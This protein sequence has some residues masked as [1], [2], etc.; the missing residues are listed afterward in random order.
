MK[1]HLICALIAAMMFMQDVRLA[2]VTG[3]VFDMEGKPVAKAEVVFKLVNSGKTYKIFTDANGQFHAVGLALGRYD[4]E[5]TGPNGRHIY[6]SNRWLYGGDLQKLNV[7]QVDLSILPPKASLVPFKGPDAK[8]PQASEKSPFTPQQIA[9]LRAVNANIAQFNRYAPD[10]EAAIRA[11]NWPKAL[12][13]LQ[14]LV[15]I[16]PYQWELYQN[17]G[18]VQAHLG[19]HA[20]AVQSFQRGIDLVLDPGAGPSDRRKAKLEAA[21]MML[22]QGDSY[23]SLNKM[24]LAAASYQRATETN[25][26]LAL[27]WM[28]LCTTKFN[29]GNEDAVE[30]C[31]QGIALAQL[32]EFYQTLASI[33]NNLGRYNESIQTYENGIRAAKA[34]IAI[35]NAGVSKNPQA[36]F[37]VP[38]IAQMLL[39][40]GNVYFQQ[41]DYA[42]AAELFRRAAPIHSYPSIAWF[43]LCATLYDMDDMQGALEACNNTIVLDP[44]MADPYYVKA[45][46]LLGVAAKRGQHKAS[47]EVTGALKK[48][49]ELAP[50][51]LYVTEARNLL[52]ESGRT[53]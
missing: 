40:E 48:Y 14:Q 6:S 45:S 19:N 21:Q 18:T 31:K 37:V 32:P 38:R 26:R 3:S 39:S 12:E 52:Q 23:N 15:K 49:L 27:A 33:Y 17:L 42:H 29:N 47:E 50:E 30:A 43:N 34:S 25:P 28:H 35:V 5:I 10:A 46:A 22:A 20:D 51:G 24:D 16:A 13:L 7:V 2:E 1:Q 8:A 4:I 53:N 36:R 41:R 44:K 11:Q 9:E